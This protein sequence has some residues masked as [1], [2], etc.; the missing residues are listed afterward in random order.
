M[1][2]S[3]ESLRV[4]RMK[5]DESGRSLIG[6]LPEHVGK[7]HRNPYAHIWERLRFHLGKSYKECEDDD[8]THIL[9][10]IEYY[11]NNPC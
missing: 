1:A 9:E 8:V 4:I 2:L 11:T 10:I 7:P 6:R 5:V 3:P